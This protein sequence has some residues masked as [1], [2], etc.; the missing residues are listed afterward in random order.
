[1]GSTK[2]A[3]ASAIRM[4]QPPEKSRVCF[5][6]IAFVNPSPCSSCAAL[7]S[8]VEASSA[9]SLREAKAHR[10]SMA[11]DV[12][13]S[14]SFVL[15]GPWEAQPVRQLRCLTFAW[16]HQKLQ[17]AK[18]NILQSQVPERCQAR[19]CCTTFFL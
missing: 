5:C 10:S 2:S 7:A 3:L 15:H 8:V 14:L 18:L 11:V 19:F 9:S 17:S 12:G 13:L 4:R 16:R 1:M 6:C